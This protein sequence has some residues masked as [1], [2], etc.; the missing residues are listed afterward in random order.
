MEE[1]E[2]NYQA[3]AWFKKAAELNHPEALL[4]LGLM[5]QEGSDPQ[6]LVEAFVCFSKAATLGQVDA[7]VRLGEC[8]EE[9]DGT[10]VD[11]AKALE[12]FDKAASLGS[13]EGC[14]RY[15]SLRIS[16]QCDLAKAEQNKKRKY[17]TDVES[18]LEA[19]KKE[20]NE[21]KKR[22]MLDTTTA[23]STA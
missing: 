7:L 3:F 12:A 18:E 9:G 22:L 16:S 11:I 17:N 5:H 20:L 2:E 15:Q 23:K 13:E 1:D 21:C 4:K 10:E 19:V 14:E 6:C 8:Y